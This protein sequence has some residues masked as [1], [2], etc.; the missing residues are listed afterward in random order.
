MDR[1]IA[2]CS[3]VVLVMGTSLAIP[4]IQALLR[5]LEDG[6]RPSRLFI[7]VNHTPPPR[8]LANL[9]HYHIQGDVDDWAAEVF[10]A[11][12]LVPPTRMTDGANKAVQ[13]PKALKNTV[14]ATGAAP[15]APTVD[16]DNSHGVLS[17]V[18]QAEARSNAE[19]GTEPE[20][21]CLAAA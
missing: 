11:F 3:D 14:I 1:D 12:G 9:F 15:V 19:N 5:A 7:F 21:L 4:G 18:A 8:K 13:R 16:K 17:E 2:A 10:L 6:S 20:P